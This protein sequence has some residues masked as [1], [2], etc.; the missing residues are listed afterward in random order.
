MKI[1]F[2]TH[3]FP[4]I[5]GGGI[6]TYVLQAARALAESGHEPV[7]FTPPFPGDSTKIRHDLA[8]AR[9]QLIEVPDVPTRVADGTLPEPL[10]R[11]VICSSTDKDS[12]V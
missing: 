11:A 3:Q 7:I 12:Y 2:L 9:I 6:G 5:R 8:A 1:A 4:G 10:T